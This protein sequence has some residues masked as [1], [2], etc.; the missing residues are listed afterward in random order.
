MRLWLITSMLW[1]TWVGWI[2]YEG[3]VVPR[4]VAANQN[5]CLEARKANPS[6][7]NPF[8]CFDGGG[9]SFADVVPWST[10]IISYGAL[11]FT[12]VLVLLL[13]GLVIRWIVAGFRPSK[14]H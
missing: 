3:A 13:I 7:G 6:L 12:P 10:D 5:A 9:M 8:D 14:T 1:I 4:L 11:A 2:A